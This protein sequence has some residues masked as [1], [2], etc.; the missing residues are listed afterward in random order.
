V[1]DQ[2]DVTG[3]DLI[4]RDDDDEKAVRT[5]IAVYREQ[6]TQ[7]AEYYCAWAESGDARAPKYFKLDGNGTIDEVRSRILA[8]L[9]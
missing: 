7:L 8:A 6:T 3:E 1:A 2:D 9:G 4:R 5:R